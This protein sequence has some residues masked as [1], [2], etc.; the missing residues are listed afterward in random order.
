M[1]HPTRIFN[2]PEELK[3]AWLKFKE[4]AKEQAKEWI[5]TQYVGKDG[6]IRLTPKKIPLT[7]EGFKRFARDRYGCIEQYFH[8]PG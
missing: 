2:E 1:A 6:D 8:K 7:F 3:Q 4:N 5:E